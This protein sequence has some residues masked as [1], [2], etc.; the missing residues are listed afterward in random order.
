MFWLVLVAGLIFI[1]YNIFF[2]SGGTAKFKSDLP[3]EKNNIK[4]KKG[5]LI[6]SSILF[7]VSLALLIVALISFL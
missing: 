1:L 3:K 6:C 4:K 5:L 2:N 7:A